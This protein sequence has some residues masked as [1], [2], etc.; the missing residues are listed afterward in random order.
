MKRYEEVTHPEPTGYPTMRRRKKGPWVKAEDALALQTKL[1]SL[2]KENERHVDLAIDE[3][4]KNVSLT[5]RCASLEAVLGRVKVTVESHDIE[6]LSC[7]RDGEIYCD[8]LDEALSD[9]PEPIAVEDT[10]PYVHGQGDNGVLIVSAGI[11]LS[12]MD[13]PVTVMV[14]KRKEH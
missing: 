12:A 10:Y 3:V 9:I 7:D 8:C 2:E 14:F 13:N 11:P 1:A 4:A 5:K 6:V